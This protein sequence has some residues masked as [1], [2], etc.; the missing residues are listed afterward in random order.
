LL[1]DL[2]ITGHGFRLRPVRMP[3]AAFIAALRNDRLRS[4]Y[5]NRGAETASEQERWLEEYFNRPDDYYFVIAR[6]GDGAEQGLLAIYDVDRNSGRAE[7][8]R[9]VLRPDSIAAVESAW[10]VYRMAFDVLHLVE[11]HCRTLVENGQVISFH[12]HCGLVRAGEVEIVVDGAPRRAI[13]HRLTRDRHPAISARLEALAAR[14]AHSID[15]P[16]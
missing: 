12:D 15:I 8:G 14:V 13:E 6:R 10:L 1:H 5:L 3:D 9:W 2:D 16:V 4:G 7:W 11:I